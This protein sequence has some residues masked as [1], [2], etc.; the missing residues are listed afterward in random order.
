MV[1]K[2][3]GINTPRKEWIPLQEWALSVWYPT[4]EVSVIAEA[5]GLTVNQVNGKI[6]K[7]GLKKRARR[8]PKQKPVVRKDEFS[9]LGMSESGKPLSEK[10]VL[11][12]R[13]IHSGVLYQA[14]PGRMV[15]RT[16]VGK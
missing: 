8:A 7:L 4:E 6:K 15:H 5:L 10:E 11:K 9:L 14:E 13:K 16:G 12:L 2:S 1:T 3:R